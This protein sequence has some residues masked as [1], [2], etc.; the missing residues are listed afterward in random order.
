MAR[1][2]ETKLNACQMKG[3]SIVIVQS[4]VR[5]LSPIHSV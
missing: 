4:H 1:E 3:Q 2:K 5:W